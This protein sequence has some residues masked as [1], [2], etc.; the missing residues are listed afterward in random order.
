MV[1]LKRKGFAEPAVASGILNG[2][3]AVRVHEDE[4]RRVAHEF[5]VAEI[6]FRAGSEIAVAGEAHDCRTAGRF[7]KG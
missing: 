3:R 2:E 5:R 1:V 7:G 4:T 6:D